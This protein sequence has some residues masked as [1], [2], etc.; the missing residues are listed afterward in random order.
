MPLNKETKP[1]F[2]K[3]QSHY[4]LID[5]SDN[6]VIRNEKNAEEIAGLLMKLVW[7]KCFAIFW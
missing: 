4:F 5:F 1:N 2:K 6:D 3:N 7:V